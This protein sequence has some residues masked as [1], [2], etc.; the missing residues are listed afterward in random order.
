[1]QK[2]KFA[3]ESKIKRDAVDFVNSSG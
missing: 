1:L 2:K 3:V